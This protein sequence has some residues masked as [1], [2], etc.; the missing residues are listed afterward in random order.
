[1][2]VGWYIFGARGHHVEVV[3]KSNDPDALDA[4]AAYLVYAIANSS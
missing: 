4:A 1:V 2:R 3:L